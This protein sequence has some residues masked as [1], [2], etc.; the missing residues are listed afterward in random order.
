MNNLY[1][2]FPNCNINVP[3]TLN[4]ANNL[5]VQDFSDSNANVVDYKIYLSNANCFIVPDTL[6]QRSISYFFTPFNPIQPHT[7][8]IY[9]KFDSINHFLSAVPAPSFINGDTVFWNV[10]NVTHI[11]NSIDIKFTFPG[12]YTAANIVPFSFGII[13]TQYPDNNLLNI[14]ASVTFPFCIA[15]DPN[16]KLAI[17]TGEGPQGE[18]N[19]YDT[20]N[21]LFTYYIN[22][23]NTGNASAYNVVVE[24]TISDKLDINTIEVLHATHNYIL[25][26]KNG[27]I[28]RWKFPYIMLPDSTTDFAGSIGT[29]VY[30]IKQAANNQIGDEIHNT[31][32]IYFDNNPPIVTNTTLHTLADTLVIPNTIKNIHEKQISIYPNPAKHNVYIESDKGIG[33]V[34]IYDVHMRLLFTEDFGKR[35]KA[36]ISTATLSNGVYILKASNSWIHKL[37]IEK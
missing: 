16:N 19:Y 36:D 13:N 15:W 2:Y 18:I 10:S 4:A 23:Q 22:F 24:D 11:F 6:K 20:Q 35:Q 33:V 5:I 32:Y 21:Q 9:A 7:A 1:G 25:E 31:A 17:P 3:V 14:H 37:V 28:L 8:T 29:I 12:N 26:I 27:N 30:Q 34:Q